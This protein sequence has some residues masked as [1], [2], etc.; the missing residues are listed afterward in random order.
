MKRL[1]FVV[2]LITDDNDYQRQQAV[3][4]QDA[5]TQLDVDVRTLFADNDSIHQSQQILDVIHGRDG[6][7]GILVEPAGRT[8]FPQAAGAAVAS[9]RAWVVLNCEPDYLKQL[10]SGGNVP[11]F[12]VSADNH[13]I[14]RI[15]GRQLRAL[16]PD[17]GLVLYLQGPSMS[18]VTEQRTA[19]MLETKPESV[20]VRI[21]KSVSWAEEGGYHAIAAWLRLSTA[22]N[23]QIDVVQAHNDSLAVGARRAIEDQ[24][25]G[26]RN[27]KSRLL[28]LGVDGLPRTGQAWVRQ[29]ILTATIVVPAVT[30][31]ALGA[32]VAA[33][34]G[35]T[36]QPECT[37]VAPTS[38]PEPSQL[39]V[40]S[41]RHERESI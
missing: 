20:K 1:R 14:G 9:G 11:T 41:I 12:S 6:I 36:S 29:G 23:E 2:S 25:G 4:A 32:L 3:A 16:L 7:D 31:Q 34:R 18:L 10:R 38:F 28:F 21:L 40:K 19:G 37:R 22:R 39:E 13:E 35:G 5:G 27:H 26:H 33:I 17:G 8:A 30:P 24:A 15:Q